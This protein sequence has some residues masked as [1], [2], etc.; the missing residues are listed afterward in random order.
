MISSFID[1]TLRIYDFIIIPVRTVSRNLV[2]PQ[3]AFG[4]NPERATSWTKRE[5]PIA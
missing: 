5:L 3:G 1:S 2:F 4:S